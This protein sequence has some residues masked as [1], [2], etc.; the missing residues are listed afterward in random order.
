[1]E[2]FFLT[3]SGISFLFFIKTLCK[4]G[5][6]ILLYP[7]KTSSPPSPTINTL[8]PSSWIFSLKENWFKKD[9]EPTGSSWKKINFSRI[10]FLISL[11]NWKKLW[12]SE[13]FFTNSLIY[14]FSSSSFLSLELRLNDLLFDDWKS[15][16][17]LT[18]EELSR[19]PDNVNAIGTSALRWIFIFSEKISSNSSLSNFLLSS[20]SNFQYFLILKDDPSIIP[21]DPGGKEYIPLKK[22]FLLSSHHPLNKYFRAVL[23]FSLISFFCLKKTI[24]FISELIINPFLYLE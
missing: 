14:F 4:Y 21:I 15:K 5:R 10:S 2:I 6:N 22:V 18:I 12:F 13:F 1:M 16:L 11:F 17:F 7:P 8:N 23:S 3:S 20:I 9:I 24:S 19:P